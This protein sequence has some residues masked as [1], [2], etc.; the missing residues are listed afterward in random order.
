M[1]NIFTDKLSCLFNF[2]VNLNSFFNDKSSL[3]FIILNKI[4]IGFEK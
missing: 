1:I 3:Y 2:M 4:F